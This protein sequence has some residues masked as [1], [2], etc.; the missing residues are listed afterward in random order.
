MTGGRLKTVSTYAFFANENAHPVNYR[1][2][3][4][5]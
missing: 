4:K 1:A 2:G 3:V 5:F